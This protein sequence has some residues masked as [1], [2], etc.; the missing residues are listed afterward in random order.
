MARRERKTAAQAWLER[1]NP[2]QGMSI[3]EAQNIFD[4]ARNGDTQ[5]LHWLFQEIEATNPVLLVCVERRSSAIAN[6]QWKISENAASDGSLSAEQKDSAERFLNGVENLTDALEHMELA[7]FRGFAHA[8]PVWEADGAVKE[9]QL[10]DSWKFVRQ[11]G[12]WFYNPACTGF[13]SDMQPTDRCGLMTVV[14][15]RPIDYPALAIHIRHAVGSRDWGRF[16][17]RYALPKP[18]V[19][20]HPGATNDQRADYIEA[21]NAVENG[22]VSVWP[23]GASLTD[24]AG[25]SRGTDPFG[26]F[27][28]HQEK[29]IV[30]LATGG[31]LMSLAEAGSGTLAGGAQSEVWESIVARDSFVIAQAVQRAMVIPYLVRAFP[32]KPVAVSFGFDFTKPPTP[33]EV[34]EVAAL[35]KQAGWRI[36]QAQL[37]EQTG[38]TL[39]EDATPSS[40]GVSASPSGG[41]PFLNKAPH[42]PKAHEGNP[43]IPAG[44]PRS[45][46]AADGT[47]A[48]APS[49]VLKAFAEDTGAAAAAV[50]KLLE[51]PTPD[52]AAALLHDLPSLIPEDPAL[53]A[54]IA[55]EMAKEFCKPVANKEGE[56]RAADPEHCRTHGTPMDEDGHTP[57]EIRRMKEYAAS[58]DQRVVDFVEVCKGIDDGDELS[59]KKCP[60]GTA[61]E[62]FGARVK[63]L[64]GIDTTGWT[65][66]LRGE[67]ARHLDI[68]HGAEGKH[69]QSLADVN[70][71]GRI[72]YVMNHF[73][74]IDILRDEKGV[75]VMSGQYNGRDGKPSP[76]IELR[77]KIDGTYA[78]QE[79][80][81]DSKW[82]KVYVVS[83]RIEKNAKER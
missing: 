78:I 21:A 46:T 1:W 41:F 20:M 25:G 56:C 3:R 60:I 77:M 11:G 17:E 14:R 47:E 63:E 37:E 58:T 53:A 81:P 27:I 7:F 61:S 33:K 72:G 29:Q 26:S 54:V 42:S 6:F 23:G 10:L 9:V 45:V 67:R 30:L 75:P 57:E 38:Y 49:A 44:G 68:R 8:Q 35:A 34:F 24:F 48:A 18:A 79:A 80:V 16:L 43:G 59:K 70:D 39:A 32:G 28:E 52:G 83:A 5:R 13:A 22:Q 55:E 66:E 65:I 64:T 19:F 15:R 31:T 71:I 76:M 74:S 36:D 12:A 51:N 4:V 50:R 40:E 69:D 73:D 2:L 62:E 82:K